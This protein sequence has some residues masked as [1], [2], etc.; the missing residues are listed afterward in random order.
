MHSTRRTHPELTTFFNVHVGIIVLTAQLLGLI[1]RR[2][3][4]PK[5]IAEVLGGILLGP[6]AFGRIPGFTNHIFPDESLSYLSLVANIGL[7]LFLFIVGLEIETSVI[8]KNARF[9]MPIALGGMCLPFGL[10]AA[11]AVPIYN[12]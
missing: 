12:R 11:L 9:S 2:I 7:V 5:V 6:T 10:G 1:L 8:K 4:Q 3:R